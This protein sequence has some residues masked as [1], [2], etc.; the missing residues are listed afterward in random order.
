VGGRYRCADSSAAPAFTVVVPSLPGFPLSPQRPGQ[1]SA[2][3]QVWHN[4][5]L[6]LGFARYGA[7]G[8]DLGA[9]ITS[10]L[11]QAHPEAVVGIHLMAV[12]APADM[13]DATLSPAE[14]EFLARTRWWSEQEGSYQHQQQRRPLSLAPALSDSPVGLLGWIV[15]KYRA[16]SDCDGDLSRRFS[17]DFLLTQASLYWY[18]NSISTSFRPYYE[19][20]NGRAT[21]VRRVE[22]PLP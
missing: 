13:D 21:P 22:V 5:M 10:R 18:T 14:R 11:A 15:E 17:D 19:Y 7:H 2:I 6:S 20:A 3:H 12:A 1:D 16:R 9:G 4:L 8:G